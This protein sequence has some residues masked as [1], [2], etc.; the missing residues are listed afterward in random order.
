MFESCAAPEIFLRGGRRS[1]TILI[2]DRRTHRQ[3]IVR[4]QTETE[5]WTA[6]DLPTA[7]IRNQQR[8]PEFLRPQVWSRTAPGRAQ[9][10]LQT[11][12]RDVS[13]IFPAGENELRD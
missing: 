6:F 5:D 13:R 10:V 1:S 11:Q 4:L 7:S 12:P 9:T 3:N 2:A 8:E